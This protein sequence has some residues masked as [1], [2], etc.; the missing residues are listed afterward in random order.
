MV[1]HVT[2]LPRR[3]GAAICRCHDTHRLTNEMLSCYD[4]SGAPSST[5]CQSATEH[6]VIIFNFIVYFIQNMIYLRLLDTARSEMRESYVFIA[7]VVV[8]EVVGTALMMLTCSA[9]AHDL[10]L[11]CTD[12]G[13][14]NW[15]P[16]AG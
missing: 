5:R 3:S 2:K 1:V 12:E 10:M 6:T 14:T 13:L 9:A 8:V 4:T 15:A 11:S 16:G 7:V